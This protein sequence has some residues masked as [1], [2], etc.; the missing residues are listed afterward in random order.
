MWNVLNIELY[1]LLTFL[2]IFSLYNVLCFL[3][4]VGLCGHYFYAICHNR[5]KFFFFLIIR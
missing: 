3:N 1:A 2:T 4:F 5:N